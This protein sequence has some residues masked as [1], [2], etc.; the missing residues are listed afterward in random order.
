MEE[1]KIDLRPLIELQKYDLQ[2]KSLEKELKDL[3]KR[4]EKL[5]ENFEIEKDALLKVKIQMEE[6]QTKRKELE[7]AIQNFKQNIANYKAQQMKKK[8]TNEEY[9]TLNEAIKAEE[10]K[11]AEIEEMLLEEMLLADEIEKEIKNREESC[12]KAELQVKME[13]EN[14][15]Q[16][17]AEIEGKIKELRSVRDNVSKNIP[18]KLLELYT[19]I[20]K[21]KDGIVLSIVKDEFCSFCN[22]RVRPQNLAE[23][24]KNTSLIFCE[25]C[26]RILYM[27]EVYGEEEK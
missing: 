19:K 14:I 21:K 4:L 17:K 7:L 9:F 12:R 1:S 16:E 20:A 8:L 26:D 13:R 5:N 27:K 11:I 3:P 18:Q 15:L 2:I 6:N 23:L 22:M 10:N 25:N 24:R